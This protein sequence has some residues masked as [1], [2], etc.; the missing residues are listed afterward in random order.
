MGLRQP[1]GQHLRILNILIIYLAV[2]FACDS[3]GTN[4]NP[5]E[6]ATPIPVHTRV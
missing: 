2:L 6:T 3:P 1:E 4:K 5:S